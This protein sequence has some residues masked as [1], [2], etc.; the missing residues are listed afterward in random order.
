[1]T[2]AET[3]LPA[4]SFARRRFWLR[5]LLAGPLAFAAAALLMLGG[6]AWLPAGR[7]Q[8][9]NLVL[10]VVLFPLIWTALFLYALLDARLLR[11][12]GVIVALLALH[13]ALIATRLWK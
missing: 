2:A 3:V 4:A 1:M 12:Y 11:A 5:T 6:T 10:P 13:G 8:I 9:D 7:A